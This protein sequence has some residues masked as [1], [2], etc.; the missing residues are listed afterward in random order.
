MITTATNSYHR[1]CHDSH[2]RGSI[3]AGRSII[4]H[5]RTPLASWLLVL[6]EALTDAKPW[7]QLDSF[8]FVSRCCLLA[9]W[10]L[11]LSP[12]IKRIGPKALR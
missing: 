6:L 4:G 11:L 2:R 7:V 9:G 1:E 5:R 3:P 10:L 8:K 12:H